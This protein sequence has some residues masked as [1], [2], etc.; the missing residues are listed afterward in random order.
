MK[1]RLK[2]IHTYLS[3]CSNCNPNEVTRTDPL[4][5]EV[6][7]AFEPVASFHC[8]TFCTTH[9]LADWFDA[10][11]QNIAAADNMCYSCNLD[12]THIAAGDNILAH[13]KR[14]LNALGRSGQIR[15]LKHF[16]SFDQSEVDHVVGALSSPH[17]QN[18]LLKLRWKKL[19][20]INK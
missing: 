3:H 20:L 4:L 1:L 9:M 14:L 18:I 5:M 6:A 10:A 17:S 19:I 7:A 2:K 8:S 16:G 12:H 11:F 13:Q 15:D